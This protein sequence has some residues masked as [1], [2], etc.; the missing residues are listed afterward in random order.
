MTEG[1]NCAATRLQSP[2]ALNDPSSIKRAMYL[3]T[4]ARDTL[5]IFAAIE[6]CEQGVEITY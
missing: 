5:N 2:P 3:D 4:A 1:R 6:A